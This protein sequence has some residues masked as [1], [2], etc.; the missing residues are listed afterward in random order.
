M[1]NEEDTTPPISYFAELIMEAQEEDGGNFP[2]FFHA[3]ESDTS[4]NTNLYDALLLGSKR[5]GHGFNVALHPKL[6][7]YVI[8]E[9]ICLEVCPISNFILGYQI[10]LRNHPARFLIN[11]GMNISINSD[12][13][14]FYGYSGVTLDFAFAFLSWELGIADLK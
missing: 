9:G 12:D 1:V 2:C 14:G 13:P 11:H 3:G 4:E 6:V 8:Q 7:D 10:D 5:I